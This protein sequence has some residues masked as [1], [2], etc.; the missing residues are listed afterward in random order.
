MSY[1]KK[2][3][4]ETVKIKEF[5]SKGHGVG[6]FL[7][8]DGE[9]EKAEVSFSIPGDEVSALLFSKRKGLYRGRIETNEHPSSDRIEP[10]CVH[11]ASC[12]GCRWQQ[13]SYERQLQYKQ[14][15]IKNTFGS[16]IGPNVELRQILPSVKEWNYRNKME[17]SFSSDAN[18]RKYLGL[19]MDSSNGKVLNLTECHL[20]NSWYMDAVKAVRYWWEESNLDSYHLFKNTGSLRT[21]TLREAFKTGDRM[22][23]LTVSGNPD[24]ALNKHHM[25]TFVS[26]IRNAVEPSGEN[27]K[28]SI[29]LRIQQIA[30][31]MPTNFY[32]MHLYG[33]D[34]IEEELEI[35]LN[36]E[37]DAHSFRFTISPATFFQPNTLQ[38][39]RFYSV[40]IQLAGITK[41][42]TVYDLYCGSGTIGICASRAAKQVIG[43]ELSP[44]AALD[45]R[46]NIKLNKCDNVVIMAGAVRHVLTQLQVENKYP[47]PDVLIVDPPRAGLDPDALIQLIKLNV[48]KILYISCNPQT[49][50]DNV[51]ELLKHGYALKVIQPID[52]F[53][54][55]VHI[56]NIVLLEKTTN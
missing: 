5:S 6:S 40:A 11:F 49:Q 26:A 39:E 19:I 17:F 13:M 23:I 41:E 8:Q 30:K 54:Q 28:L 1:F 32:E 31:G 34:Y 52:Q 42:S 47:A 55:T 37:A 27:S 9:Q 46:Q 7:R 51:Q 33:A 36:P 20:V 24:Y 18:Q 48:P 45:A 4:L 53:P 25:E 38:A 3:R 29:F 50:A 35:K 14:D 12:G 15:I 2:S 22:V 56:E 21:L 16:L 43:I 10:K 44:E